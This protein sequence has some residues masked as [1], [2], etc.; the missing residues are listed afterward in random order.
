MKIVFDTN[1]WIASFIAR[2][3]CTDLVEHS[4][5]NHTILTSDFILSEIQT[6]LK[7][8]F[9]YSNAV[10]HRTI[11][12]IESNS[13]VVIIEALEHQVCR[14]PDDDYI[15]A[16]GKNGNADCIIS[17]DQ[18]LIILKK[19][20]QIPILSPKDFWAFEIG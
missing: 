16:T 13:Q 19:F 18:D 10:I 20:E 12:F 17:G 14:D 2:G 3:V 1:V 5:R 15:L 4:V 7:K 6:V 8:K 9:K 11:Q